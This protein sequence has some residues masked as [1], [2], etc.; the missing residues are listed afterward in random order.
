VVLAKDRPVF[1]NWRDCRWLSD[2]PGERRM[3]DDDPGVRVTFARRYPMPIASL[4]STPVGIAAGV[5]AAD[6]RM[7]GGGGQDGAAIHGR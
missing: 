6:L 5:P 7:A 3:L 4:L 1:R 2:I